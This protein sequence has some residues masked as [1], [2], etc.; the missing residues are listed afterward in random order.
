MKRHFT[1]L[2]ALS[3]FT[4]LA[5][6]FDFEDRPHGLNPPTT[7]AGMH[8]THGN[9]TGTVSV[10]S[11]VNW[12]QTRNGVFINDNINLSWSGTKT[13]YTDS[14]E[15]TLIGFTT[16]ART[17]SIQ[18]DPGSEG[19]DIIRLIGLKELNT[20]GQYEVLTFDQAFD[21]EQSVAGTT[22]EFTFQDGVD[23]VILQTTTENEAWDNL[24][25]TPVPEPASM[26]ALAAGI[27]AML[28]RKRSK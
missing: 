8:I 25:V 12:S 18:S 17:V 27:A 9:V 19:P 22:L 24:N 3:P 6:F 4:T 21:N 10:G 7:Y 28:K 23:F 20:P 16:K 1:T 15:D 5:A 26:A 11:T 14:L 13:I 2:L